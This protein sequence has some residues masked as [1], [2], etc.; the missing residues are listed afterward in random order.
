MGL[1]WQQGP[2]TPGRALIATDRR[3]DHP[4]PGC[5]DLV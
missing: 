4:G 3:S 5:G 2:L 1:A